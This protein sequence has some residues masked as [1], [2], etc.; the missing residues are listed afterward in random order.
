MSSRSV[1]VPVVPVLRELLGGGVN[2]TLPPNLGPLEIVTGAPSPRLKPP[3]PKP[4][5]VAFRS[6]RARLTAVVNSRSRSVRDVV[7]RIELLRLG[8]ITRGSPRR[9]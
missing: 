8:P 1:V 4:M 2:H 6:T 9:P 5:P 7:L 3:M